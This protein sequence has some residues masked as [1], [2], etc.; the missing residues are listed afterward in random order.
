MEVKKVFYE[1]Y[2]IGML[3][4]NMNMWLCDWIIRGGETGLNL[5]AD[6]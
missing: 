5:Y 2:K 6:N 4:S 3:L 1:S